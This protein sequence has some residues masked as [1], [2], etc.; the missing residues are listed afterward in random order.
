MFYLPLMLLMLSFFLKVLNDWN[1]RGEQN[2]AVSVVA[3]G[4]QRKWQEIQSTLIARLRG[5]KKLKAAVI[6]LTT[7][8]LRHY[9]CAQKIAD[10]QPF[11]KTSS[12]TDMTTKSPPC[13][14]LG[15][16]PLFNLIL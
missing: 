4:K 15:Q 3:D 2:G 8:E 7:A 10:W 11:F 12:G 5:K 14:F 9:A 1:A 6:K 16:S 13:A